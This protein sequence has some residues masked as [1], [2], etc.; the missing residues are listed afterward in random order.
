MSTVARRPLIVCLAL[1]VG[2]GCT[3]RSVGDE[4]STTATETAATSDATEA[5]GSTS[6]TGSESESETGP[7]C[8]LPASCTEDSLANA[9]G[10]GC[11]P[12]VESVE[13]VGDP[14][15]FAVGSGLA[16]TNYFDPSSA[17]TL[18][19]STGRATALGEPGSS[20]CESATDLEPPED[21]LLTPP[22]TVLVDEPPTGE[23]CD[24][25][26]EHVGSYDCSGTLRPPFNVTVGPML[27]NAH[28]ST[29]VELTGVAPMDAKSFSVR[30]AY[31][32]C[33]YPAQWGFSARDLAYVWLETPELTAN[34]LYGEVVQALQPGSSLVTLLDGQ[35]DPMPGNDTCP[36]PDQT[37]CSAPELKN[38]ALEGHGATP[39]LELRAPVVPGAP[40]KIHI[41]MFDALS[42][43]LDGYLTFE[44][45]HWSCD[46]AVQPWVVP[47]AE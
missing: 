37:T 6:E 27:D 21:P 35:V 33:A 24:E 23:P 43:A 2:V 10:F 1:G 34:V 17:R 38:T 45:F 28:D 29:Y 9:A 39:W 30:F 22:S 32:T 5:S 11:A 20:F 8:S 40:F 3:A 12:G 16:G 41:G 47:V 4:T 15:G 14:L 31:L 46:E 13:F 18:V 42:P 44:G 19:V 25:F 36:L 26:P 7:A